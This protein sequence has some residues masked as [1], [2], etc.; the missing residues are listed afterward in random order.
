MKIG[1]RFLQESPLNWV[2][3]FFPSGKENWLNIYH[4][5]LISHFRNTFVFDF[6]NLSNWIHH[7]L[8]NSHTAIQAAINGTVITLSKILFT[9]L[10]SQIFLMASPCFKYR[11]NFS[12]CYLS[13]ITMQ[14]DCLTSSCF[15]SNFAFGFAHGKPI[16]NPKDII[17]DRPGRFAS[18]LL[19]VAISFYKKSFGTSCLRLLLKCKYVEMDCFQTH[20]VSVFHLCFA[21]QKT[22]WK[23]W[24]RFSL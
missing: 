13:N 15:Y 22:T 14:L 7:N 21:F 11:F 18:S 4:G 20:G 10:Y 17:F 23:E 16:P 9:I 6:L 8:S 24:W 5:F 12:L 2:L 19:W 3:L 1:L